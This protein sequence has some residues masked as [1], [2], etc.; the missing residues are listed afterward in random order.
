M[1]RVGR[2]VKSGTERKRKEEKKKKKTVTCRSSQAV[3]KY[4]SCATPQVWP[5]RDR[6][7]FVQLRLCLLVFSEGKIF[8][9]HIE[10]NE[11]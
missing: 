4:A 8:L 2:N 3:F 9:A 7:W 1:L 5:F 11:V 6:G 10:A